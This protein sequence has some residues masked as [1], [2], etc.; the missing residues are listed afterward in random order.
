MLEQYR[1]QNMEWD[2][3]FDSFKKIDLDWNSWPKDVDS[4]EL[5]KINLNSNLEVHD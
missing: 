2:I 5:S 4:V 3:A 1:Y